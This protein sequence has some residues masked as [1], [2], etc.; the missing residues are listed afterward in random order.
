MNARAVPQIAALAMLCV[1]QMACA[2]AGAAAG[3]W[4]YEVVK[5]DT[6]IG[7][8]AQ[9]A[10]ASQW[11]ALRSLNKIDDPHR[12]MPGTRL[13]IPTAWLRPSAAVAEVVFVQGQAFVQRRRTGGQEEV[14][15]GSNLREH[16]TI[17]TDADSS[18]TLRFVDG[19]RLLVIPDSELTIGRLLTYGRTGIS[20]VRLRLA[21]GH[22]DAQVVPAR[23]KA[24]RFEIST[25]AVNLGV[26]GTEFRTRVD[27]SDTSTRVEVLQGTVAA[28]TR[29]GET[30]IGAGFGTV[31]QVGQRTDAP[32]RLAGA[33]DL[34]GV[35][36]LLERVPL[37]LAWDAMPLA[38]GYRAQVFPADSGANLLLD[39]VFTNPSAKWA[40]LP[41]GRY[42]L[43]VRA[44]DAR[45]LEGVDAS[46]AFTLKARPEP[47]FTQAPVADGKYYG[48]FATFGW[49]V[50]KVAARY[51]LQVTATSDFDAPYFDNA[52]ITA[53]QY[54]LPL[55]PGTYQWRI[56]SIAAD[57]DQG[58]FSDAQAFTQRQIPPSPALE[59]A[60][61][62]DANLVLRWRAPGAGETVHFQ[63]ASDSEFRQ[64]LLDL[65]TDGAQALLPKPA[66]G[67]YY[68]RA[69]TIDADGF[70]GDFGVTQH[71]EVPRSTWWLLIPLGVFLHML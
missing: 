41:D 62:V 45:G 25:P 68:L 8:A 47:P 24:T 55:A 35:P 18:V 31:V 29:R 44:L 59:P 9:L 65:R 4:R 60:Q 2:Q 6:L 64:V 46:A 30:R 19:S 11:P 17:H 28:V 26:R 58:P 37:R 20:S 43:R 71:V 21:K 13:R 10:Q 49:A 32:L 50:P 7:I 54:R 23:T 63:V 69:R 34:N 39:G 57:G 38:S 1:A 16:D 22:A 36:A 40:D 61:V 53:A 42:V 14:V 51:R 27:P 3:E 66:P 56:A 15:V 70:E 52:D 12:L 48:E 33:P 67:I 5:G